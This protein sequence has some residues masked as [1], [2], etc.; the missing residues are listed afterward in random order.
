MKVQLALGRGI[1]PVCTSSEHWLCTD[2]CCPI[3]FAWQ[4]S[5]VT[6][7][8]AFPVLTVWLCYLAVIDDE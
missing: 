2:G 6:C 5:G 8:F 4:D 3:V 7:G 1:G